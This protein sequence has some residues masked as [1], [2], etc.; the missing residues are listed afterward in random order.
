M[1]DA[2][3]GG[4]GTRAGFLPNVYSVYSFSFCD[5][6]LLNNSGKPLEFQTSKKKKSCKLNARINYDIGYPK[7]PV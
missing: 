4:S 7:Y 2:L 1:G 6:K 3:G 5:E